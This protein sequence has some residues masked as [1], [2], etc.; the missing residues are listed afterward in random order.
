MAEYQEYIQTQINA[1]SFESEM[2]SWRDGQ[3]KSIEQFLIPN[4]SKDMFILDAACGDGVGVN[5]LYHNGYTNVIGVEINSAKID[6]ARELYK[7]VPENAI[8]Y[9]DISTLTFSDNSFDTVWC[10]H[11]LEHAYEPKLVLAEFKRV[12][13]NNGIVHIIVPYP[14]MGCKVHCA[15]EIL[16]LNIGE[17]GGDGCQKYIESL[18]FEVLERERLHIREPELYL[19]IKVS[20]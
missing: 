19:K 4:I 20:K 13:K 3:I 16:K 14:A 7:T 2:I 18:G 9:M 8:Q 17:D 10:S 5:Y 15:C 6:K 11:T 12:I 1:C